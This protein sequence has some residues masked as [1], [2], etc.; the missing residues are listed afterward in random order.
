METYE[1]IDPMVSFFYVMLRDGLISP[2]KLE[3]LVSDMETGLRDHDVDT[4]ILSNNHLAEYA[5]E[6]VARLNNLRKR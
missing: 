6:L 2:G 3:L 4:W 5:V 1:T